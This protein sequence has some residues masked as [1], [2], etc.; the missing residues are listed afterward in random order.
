RNI[1]FNFSIQKQKCFRHSFWCDYSSSIW[2]LFTCYN[3][4]LWISNIKSLKKDELK[5]VF[6]YLSKCL[7]TESNFSFIFLDLSLLSSFLIFVQL[8]INLLSHLQLMCS[9]VLIENLFYQLLYV[10][11][12]LIEY[13]RYTHLHLV[14]QSRLE[15]LRHLQLPL[16]ILLIYYLCF[17]QSCCTNN[18]CI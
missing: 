12:K 3:I 14:L 16:C 10:F 15:L 13:Q 17:N 2:F 7:C 6:F 4:H 9:L 8:L 5:L 11:P 18:P 1:R